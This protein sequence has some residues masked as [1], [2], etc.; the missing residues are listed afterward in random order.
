ML[1]RFSVLLIVQM[2]CSVMLVLIPLLMVVIIVPISLLN[3]APL[4]QL[5][6]LYTMFYF[7]QVYR[8][9]QVITIQLLMFVVDY[10]LSVD[11][12]W[13]MHKFECIIA[14]LFLFTIL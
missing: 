2:L 11:Y 6:L 12:I 4:V 3:L 9:I 5:T 7:S 1:L 10:I 14:A 8:V 13:I